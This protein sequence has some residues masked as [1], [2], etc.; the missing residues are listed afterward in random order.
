MHCQ[1]CR[2]L[3]VSGTQGLRRHSWRATGAFPDWLLQCSLVP[4]F[5]TLPLPSTLQM[6][7]TIVN[8]EV[9]ATAMANMCA[10]LD[11]LFGYAAAGGLEDRLRRPGS[12]AAAAAAGGAVGVAGV[13]AGAVMAPA[14]Y[15]AVRPAVV[16]PV[17]A[18]RP[19]PAPAPA[20]VPAPA[21]VEATVNVSCRYIDGRVVVLPCKPSDTIASLKQRLNVSGCWMFAVVL[22]LIGFAPL[23]P[24]GAGIDCGGAPSS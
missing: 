18:P 16:A 20:P 4:S 23:V 3:R 2:R 13:P 12:V 14:V 6:Q 9:P 8:D 22:L 1:E 17:A 19:A 24:T 11:R 5:L 7:H 10:E 15:P 21:A